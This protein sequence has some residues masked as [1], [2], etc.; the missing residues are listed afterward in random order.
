[1]SMKFTVKKHKKFI[2]DL[3]KQNRL[4]QGGDISEQFKKEAMFILE[5]EKLLKKVKILR[6]KFDIPTKRKEAEIFKDMCECS[7][8]D[9]ED[10]YVIRNMDK[11]NKE[12]ESLTKDKDYNIGGK[13][14]D[15]FRRFVLFHEEL[16]DDPICL[17]SDYK[18]KKGKGITLPPLEDFKIY[19]K[20]FEIREKNGRLFIEIF[21]HTLKKQVMSA[22]KTEIKPMQKK[23]DRIDFEA[24]DISKDKKNI[25]KKLFK[26]YKKEK[27]CYEKITEGFNNYKLEELLKGFYG[28]KV[29]IEEHLK[30]L[31]DCKN[32]SLRKKAINI[33][34]K[35]SDTNIETEEQIIR[36]YIRRLKD[37]GEIQ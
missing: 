37:K 27:D 22:W 25:L 16:C 9:L 14:K 26:K 1:M 28:K 6:K 3:Y 29:T 8:P 31:E 5:N 10:Y 32:D 19:D 15:M 33:Q 11:F 2:N 24:I 35:I 12:F 13:M 30:N 34:K 17:N 18:Y 7:D 21:P 20:G 36:N 4:Y 23:L